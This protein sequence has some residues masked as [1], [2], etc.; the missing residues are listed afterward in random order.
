[1]C[2]SSQRWFPNMKIRK[3][4]MLIS[5]AVM[6]PT[7]CFLL[8]AFRYWSSFIEQETINNFNI[9]N[10]RLVRN[11]EENIERRQMI[12]RTLCES[13][14]IKELVSNMDYEETEQLYQIS[15]KPILDTLTETAQHGQMIWII[16]YDNEGYEE[17]HND[18]EGIFSGV[19][20]NSKEIENGLKAVS[21]THLTLPTTSRV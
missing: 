15:V 14:L 17:I 11:I 19:K 4:L 10:R 9:T 18:Y 1:M 8:L 16:R 5:F 20:K 2:F 7:L 13:S 3:K 6:I 21:Y 12:V